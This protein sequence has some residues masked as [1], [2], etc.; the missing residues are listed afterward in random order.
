MKAIL[1]IGM[2]KT[3]TSSIQ[4]TFAAAKVNGLRYFD[5]YMPNHGS[6]VAAINHDPSLPF[7]AKRSAEELDSFVGKYRARFE[8][9]LSESDTGTFLVSA[10]RLYTLTM[11][12]AQQIKAFF[13]QYTN[14]FQIIVYVREP[15]SYMASAFQQNVKTGL[16]RFD[17]VRSV[18]LYRP[19]I[20]IYDKLFG[21]K[22]VEIRL[23][24][25]ASLYQGDVVLDFAKAIGFPL[26]PSDVQKD[27]ESLSAEAVALLFADRR[28]GPGFNRM[29][30]ENNA[31]NRRFIER[32]STIQ[33]RKFILD[34]EKTTALLANRAADIEWVQSRM[35][36][37]FPAPKKTGE[38]VFSSTQDLLDLA[39]ASH[40]LL[41]Q[42]LLPT[43]AETPRDITDFFLATL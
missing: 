33:G 10:E 38:V 37:R 18:P 17:I 39:M 25:R 4:N 26:D 41:R 31:E 5:W 2:P 42:A 30:P 9:G 16:D 29:G 36:R 1:H 24:D 27:N 3:G 40:D 28:L 32:L 11:E 43:K 20:S 22:N 6:L 23:F 35:G 13:S 14:D 12:Q 19:A 15:T 21:R 8:Q 7:V 34:P